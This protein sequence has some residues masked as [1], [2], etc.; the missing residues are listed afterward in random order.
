MQDSQ[1]P[2]LPPL[3]QHPVPLGC[4]ETF[5]LPVCE[6]VILPVGLFWGVV[7]EAVG[8]MEVFVLGSDVISV[9]QS[10]FLLLT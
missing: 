2:G 6:A 3:E 1:G 10:H 7:W 8:E 5:L 9:G 4:G